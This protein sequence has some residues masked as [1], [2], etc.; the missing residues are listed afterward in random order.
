MKFPAIG[1][2]ATTSVISMVINEKLNLALELMIQHGHRHIVIR[3][4]AAFRLLSIMDIIKIQ[5]ENIFLQTSL[6]EM[7]LPQI[8]TIEKHKNVLEALELLSDKN[9]HICVV[10]QDGTLFGFVTQSDIIANIDPQTLMENYRL[11]DFLKLGR[12]VKMVEKAAKTANVLQQMA[13]ESIDNVIVVDALK[14][15][16]I[17][18]TKDVMSLI[19]K[20]VDMELSVFEYM[21]TPVQTIQKT[22]SIKEALEYLK[23]KNFKR[24]VVVDE[25]G[26]LEGVIAQKEL[27]YLTYSKWAMLMKE[28]QDEL[29]EINTLL[30]SKSQ[31]YE[32]MA[33]FDS[34]TGLYNRYKFGEL[35]LTSYK[36]MIQRENKLSLIL[37]DID[38]FKKVNDTFGHNVGDEVLRKV[39]HKLLQILR[40]IDIVCRW[41]GE[42]FVVLLPTVNLTQALGLAENIRLNIENLLIETVA[43]VTISLGVSEVLQGDSMNDVIQ[44]ADQALYLAKKSGR[45]CV[46]PELDI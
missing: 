5:G 17:L 24:V 41:G 36:A 28:H 29:Y 21:S 2:I 16:G 26:N 38:Y 31:E 25:A 13:E 35:Y 11:Q 33:T 37:V 4:R 34:L 19:K 42:E 18:T 6:Q 32:M 30:K 44:R 40:N 15:I 27:I 23:I 46:K 14:P 10:N 20:Q 22:A 7:R 39:A 43:H 3:E 1:D 8:P 45:N 12:H 9:E